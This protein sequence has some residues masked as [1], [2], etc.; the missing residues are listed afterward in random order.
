MLLC[1]DFDGVIVDGVD[2]CLMVSWLAWHRNPVPDTL[3]SVLCDVADDFRDSFE[4]LRNYVR[5]DR[6]FIV[7]F[8]VDNG[9]DIREQSDFD[10]LFSMINESAV[11]KFATA[12][13]HIRKEL[14]RNQPVLWHALHR[15]YPGIESVFESDHSIYI[16]S[17]KDTESI[18]AICKRNNMRVDAKNVFGGLTNK[19]DVLNALFNQSKAKETAMIFCDDNLR[20]V[21][22]SISIGISTIWAGWGYSTEEQVVAAKRK[23]I[24]PTSISEFVSKVGA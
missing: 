16:V 13:Q 24:Y 9:V 20:N 12:F 22:E 2:E 8:F 6:H 19:V 11:E 4:K 15:V 7:P 18:N 23:D 14:R 21:L 5:H 1:L 10:N 17:G 3:D